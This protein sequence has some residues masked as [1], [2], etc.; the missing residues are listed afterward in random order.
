MVIQPK[1][2]WHRLNGSIHCMLPPRYQ[3]LKIVLAS[4]CLVNEIRLLHCLDFVSTVRGV[5][6][7]IYE[8]YKGNH[9]IILAS[10]YFSWKNVA[11]RA[12][13]CFLS[14]VTKQVEDIVQYDGKNNLI[15]GSGKKSPDVLCVVVIQLKC[16]KNAI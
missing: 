7:T 14:H 2:E 10:L 12:T 13:V 8:F 6:H 9:S 16:A 4:F 1:Y 5:E 11:A 15:G 3:E